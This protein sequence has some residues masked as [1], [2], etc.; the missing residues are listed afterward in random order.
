MNPLSSDLNV[1]RQTLVFGGLES[2]AYNANRKSPDLR[3]FEFGNVYLFSP[4]KQNADNPMA[5]YKEETHL[6]LWVTGKRVSGSWAHPDE[7]SNFYELKAYVMNILTRVGLP[8]GSVIFKQSEN[9]IFA[10]ATAIEHRGGKLL[11]EMGVLSRQL[12]KQAGIDRE[13]YYADIN[14]TALTKVVRKNTISYR[15]ISKFA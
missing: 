2:I 12:Q 4:D 13:V 7:D 5:A 9:D 10:Q 15:E 14:W 8:F 1:M 11:V 6:G 3:F